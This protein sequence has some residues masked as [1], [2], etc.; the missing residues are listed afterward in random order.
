[1]QTDFATAR[2]IAGMIYATAY[3]GPGDFVV[4]P[5]GW[6]DDDHFVVLVGAKQWLVNGNPNYSDPDDDRCILVNKNSGAV[7]EHDPQDI[8]DKLD[9]MTPISEDN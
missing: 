2:Q 4:A 5:Y 7:E 1:M 8:R 3:R 9:K 6:E